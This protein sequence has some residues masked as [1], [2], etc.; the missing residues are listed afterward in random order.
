MVKAIVDL[1]ERTNRVVNIVKA[2]Y[3]LKDKSE[4]IGRMVQ[5]YEKMLL[6]PALR[7]K[8]I[9]KMEKRQRENIAKVTDF[10]KRYGL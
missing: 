2:K 7:P 10:K 5:E 9:K 4:A 1:D 6:E 8:F 3:G